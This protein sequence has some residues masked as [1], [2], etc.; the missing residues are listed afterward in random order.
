MVA[1]L[2]VAELLATA[3]PALADENPPGATAVAPNRPIADLA[4]V[5]PVAD[6]P[7]ASPSGLTLTR[8]SPAPEPA[9]NLIVKQWWFWAALGA[10]VAGT[11]LTIVLVDS[12]PS[13]PNTDL[14]NREFRP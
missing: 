9:D 6:E 14:G 13:S 5:P 1:M 12:G 3:A 4:A 11:V 8:P 10:A 7:A 2:A